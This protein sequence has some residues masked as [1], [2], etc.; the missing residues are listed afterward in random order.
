MVSS[1]NPKIS[2][3]LLSSSGHN[4]HD[5]HNGH[6]ESNTRGEYMVPRVQLCFL[7]EDPRIFADRVAKAYHDRK[8]TEAELRSVLFIDCMPIDGTGKLDD[9]RV[10]R[11]IELARTSAISKT[12]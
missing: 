9:E 8:R 5:E 11:M 7:A 4:G 1:N 6:H 2:F 3:L 10:K 12:L